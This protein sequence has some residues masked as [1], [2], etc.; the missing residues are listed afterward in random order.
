MRIVSVPDF[1]EL[2]VN[3]RLFN[4]LVYELLNS[5]RYHVENAS[6]RKVCEYH[7]KR[8]ED[9]YYDVRLAYGDYGEEFD[10]LAMKSRLSD[11]VEQKFPLNKREV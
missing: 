9:L 8:F 10:F 1:G 7:L 11:I 2:I 4:S 3:E 5:F 6:S